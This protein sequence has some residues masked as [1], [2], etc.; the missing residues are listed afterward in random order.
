MPDID[1]D[2]KCRCGWCLGFDQYVQYHDEEWGVPVWED[3][4]QFEFLVLESAQ[5]GLSW[6]TI[7]KKRSGYHDAFAAFDYEKVALFS[8]SD[9]QTLLG[10]PAIVRNQLKIRAAIHNARKFIEVQEAYGSFCHY[11][12]NFVDGRPIQNQWK[13][14]HELPANSSISDKLAKDLKQ[15]GFKFLGTT[16]IYAHM[17]ATGLVND[18]LVDCWRYEEVKN[19]SKK[20]G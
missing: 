12:W 3:K 1:Q 18:H 13:S 14:L 17:Q 19:W 16:I 10:N 11:I 6:S 7:L 8:E 2:D 9:V 20:K 4:K 15:R 5:A